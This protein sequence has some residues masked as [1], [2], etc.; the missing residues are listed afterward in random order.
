[1]APRDPAVLDA[2]LDVGAKGDGVADDTEALQLGLE[3]SCARKGTSTEILRIPNG[4][5]LFSVR[6]GLVLC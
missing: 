6:I 3:M 1:M 5:R 4:T 2:R